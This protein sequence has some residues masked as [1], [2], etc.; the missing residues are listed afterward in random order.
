M[1][2]WEKMC[3]IYNR[4]GLESKLCGL[5]DETF[6]ADDMKQKTIRTIKGRDCVKRIAEILILLCVAIM[7]GGCSEKEVAPVNNAKVI[8]KA[9]ETAAEAAECVAE[10]IKG[11]VDEVKIKQVGY[12]TENKESFAIEAEY[13]VGEEDRVKVFEVNKKDGEVKKLDGEDSYSEFSKKELNEYQLLKYAAI[14]LRNFTVKDEAGETSYENSKVNFKLLDITGDNKN[15]LVVMGIND[16]GNLDHFQIYT[17]RGGDIKCIEEN[18]CSF[19]ISSIGGIAYYKDKY[20]VYYESF[21]AADEFVQYLRR[22]DSDEGIWKDYEKS[23]IM[24]DGE[25]QIYYL[26]DKKVEKDEYNQHHTALSK[27]LLGTGDF[28]TLEEIASEC[29]VEI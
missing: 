13:T 14:N 28:Y 17:N 8:S 21:S 29:E 7:L 26:N 22:Y 19:Y 9:V 16:E 10:F 15:E 4:E 11:E 27:T 24:R 23:Y 2:K 20:Y 1:T 5:L 3:I 12:K 25:K 18:R 6:P